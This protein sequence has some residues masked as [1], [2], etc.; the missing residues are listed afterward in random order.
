VCYARS[1]RCFACPKH[2]DEKD[3]RLRQGYAGQANSPL[4]AGATSE[5]GCLIFF[6]RECMTLTLR[7]R[8]RRKQ[9]PRAGHV[10]LPDANTK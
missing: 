2:L 4:S 7:Q 10:A 6:P 3:T 5:G 1:T 9:R 8:T